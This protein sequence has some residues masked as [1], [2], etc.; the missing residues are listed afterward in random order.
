MENPLQRLDRAIH[1]EAPLKELA[2][3]L[4]MALVTPDFQALF[5]KA[6]GNVQKLI[7]DRYGAWII[8]EDVPAAEREATAMR[9]QKYLSS[10]MLK[11]YNVARQRGIIRP[12]PAKKDPHAKPQPQAAAKKKPSG[13]NGGAAPALAAVPDSE[14][15]KK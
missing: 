15:E 7:I 6:N 5:V 10:M 4:C 9:R 1:Q 3:A 13:G 2:D 12:P 8:S 14:P 11:A